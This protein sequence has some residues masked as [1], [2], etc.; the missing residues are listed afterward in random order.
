M[1]LILVLASGSIVAP[2]D[3]GVVSQ[4]GS[5]DVNQQPFQ[6][7]FHPVVP[8]V[9]QVNSIPIRVQN[10]QFSEVAAAS[11]ENQNVYVDGS[12]NYQVYPNKAAYIQIQGGLDYVVGNVFNPAFQDFMKTVVPTYPTQDV[13]DQSGNVAQPG[14]LHSRDAIR[15]KVKDELQAKA[16]SYGIQVLDVFITNIHFDKAYAASIEASAVSQQHLQQAENE[17]KVTVTNAQAKATSNKLLADSINSNLIAYQNSLNQA[18]A[19]ER[20]DGKMPTYDGTGA[21][22]ILIQPGAAKSP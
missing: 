2:G 21:A 4:G 12:V 7:G 1:A 17:A 6:Q 14:I 9:T 16:Q 8:F 3:V 5:I 10:H 15:N 11:K 18:A 20:W 13:L 22:S 19:I